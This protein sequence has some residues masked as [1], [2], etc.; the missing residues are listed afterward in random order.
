MP[1][2]A[3]IAV[4]SR[5]RSTRS[6]FARRFSTSRRSPDA[7]GC[8]GGSCGSMA[9][10][11]LG[12]RPIERRRALAPLVRERAQIELELEASAEELCD[13]EGSG[14]ASLA[15]RLYCLRRARA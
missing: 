12:S 15:R 14:A 3:D 2:W 7:A 1:W 8:S 6:G 4:R 5:S 11:T 9:S 13:L 10:T